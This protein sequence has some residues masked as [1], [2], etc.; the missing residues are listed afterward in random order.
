MEI[1]I[2]IQ[3]ANREI[4]VDVTEQADHVRS[5]VDKAFSGEPKLLWLTDTKGNLVAVPVEKLA[6]VEIMAGKEE[7][8]VGFA[9][10]G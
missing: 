1:A 9:R 2:G 6:Y 4:R 8:R 5:L 3:H 7:K 10:E